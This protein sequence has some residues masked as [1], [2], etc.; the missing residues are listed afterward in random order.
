MTPDPVYPE[1]IL[2]L[3][4]DLGD[5][6]VIE[7]GSRRVSAAETL[8]LTRRIAG[9]LRTAGVGPGTRLALIV[10]VTP[11][12]FATHLA[13]HALG[14]TVCGVR[15]GLTGAQLAHLLGEQIDAVVLDA[16]ADPDQVRTASPTARLLSLD[17]QPQTHDLLAAPDDG[18]PLTGQ[19]RPDDLARITYTSGSTGFPKGCAQTYRGLNADWPARPDRWGP[20]LRAL[21]AGLARYLLF[22]TLSSQVAMDYAVL[23]LFNGGTLVIADDPL[24][25]PFFPA[26]IARHRITGSILSVPRLYQMLDTLRSEPVDVSSLRALMVSGSPLDPR[27]FAEALK[28]L[29]PV[30]FQGYGQ[31]ETG[32]LTMLGPAEASASSSALASVGR[33]LAGTRVEIR[34]P[35]GGRVPIGG[36]GEVF[37]RTPYQTVGYLAD[38]DEAAEVYVDGW[39]RTRDLGR[40]DDEGYLHLAG[41]ARE[42]I[43]VN[44]NVQYAGPIE[45]VLAGHPG[46]DQAYVV[47]G[48]DPET[49]EAAHAFIVAR[50][51]PPP[52]AT[53]LRQL[54]RDRLG[55]AAV[56]RSVTMID[57]VPMT[58]NGK[59]D[60]LALLRR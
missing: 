31:S 22:G 56:P 1:T 24:P 46:V 5:R 12:A 9:G 49:G 48:P 42:V 11:E 57:S 17:A 32:L 21:G 10:G 28:L 2:T 19:S 36:T 33:P 60:K 18:E 45:R 6:T 8:T 40:L 35:D 38:A 3:L 55:P 54:V 27:R 25:D 39:V 53:E 30:V 14:A 44:A 23:A 15:P 41:R 13:A 47:P 58:A 59:P 4:H 29:G 34:D 37:V 20:Q 52:S 7:H 43:I 16:T 50:T 26:V 51:E